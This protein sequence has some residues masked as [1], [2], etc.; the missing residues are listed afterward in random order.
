MN[1][2]CFFFSVAQI[3]THTKKFGGISES[4]GSF[5]ACNKQ[6]QTQTFKYPFRAWFKLICWSCFSSN[7][8]HSHQCNDKHNHLNA[9]TNFINCSV[10]LLLKRLIMRAKT[11][12][13]VIDWS[14]QHMPIHSMEPQSQMFHFATWKKNLYEWNYCILW[15]SF[16]M[17]YDKFDFIH[18]TN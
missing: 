4:L 13:F 8:K 10:L 17:T 9:K 7:G 3:L 6:T 2:E 11:I 16:V 18:T 12:I 14:S 15:M 5:Y 1:Q